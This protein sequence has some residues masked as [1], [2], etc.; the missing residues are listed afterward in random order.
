MKVELMEQAADLL[1]VGRLELKRM[2]GLPDP[3]RPRSEAEATPSR[4]RCIPA[5]FALAW[6][7][8][9]LQDRLYD[10]RHAEVPGN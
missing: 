2:C 5:I 6:G 9:W 4:N 7:L 3:L 1:S 10:G 8:G